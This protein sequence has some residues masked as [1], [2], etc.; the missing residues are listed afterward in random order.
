[1]SEEWY[2]HRNGQQ[3]G[4]LSSSQLQQMA[5]AGSLGPNDLVAKVGGSS[6]TPASQ[7]KGVFSKSPPSLPPLPMATSAGPSGTRSALLVVGGIIGCLTV[8][9]CFGLGAIYLF[10]DHLLPETIV[11]SYDLTKDFRTG[12]IDADRK[13]RNKTLVVHGKIKNLDL[14]KQPVMIQLQGEKDDADVSCLFEADEA[15]KLHPALR[16]G[17]SVMVRGRYVSANK[18][19]GLEA[20]YVTLGDCQVT[21]WQ[22]NPNAVFKMAGD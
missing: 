12:M 4:P 14:S 13:Y 16:N 3:I 9:S 10:A 6:W 7:V 19:P 1:M 18:L 17:L 15:S 5:D 22:G 2:V 20:M 8:I 21:N 11:S